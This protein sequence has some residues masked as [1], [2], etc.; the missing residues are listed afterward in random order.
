MGQAAT[1]TSPKARES[2]RLAI[3]L[4]PGTGT[5]TP[6]ANMTLEK[7]FDAVGRALENK[8]NVETG[9]VLVAVGV[10]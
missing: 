8:R 9:K 4:N 6:K 10:K 7:M 3:N 5:A 1:G 2:Q